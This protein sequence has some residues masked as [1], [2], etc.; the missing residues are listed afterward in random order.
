MGQNNVLMQNRG[1]LILE[2]RKYVHTMVDKYTYTEK[3]TQFS[4]TL[5]MYG[6]KYGYIRKCLATLLIRAIRPL[7]PIVSYRKFCIPMI[8]LAYQKTSVDVFEYIF[9]CLIKTRCRDWFPIS[10]DTQS[11]VPDSLTRIPDD[12]PI[13][14]RI[15]H[16]KGIIWTSVK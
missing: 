8:F 6:S 9:L 5:P 11:D 4:I 3:H 16:A 10:I 12:T 7:I 1:F 15:T 13:R 14:F 2:L